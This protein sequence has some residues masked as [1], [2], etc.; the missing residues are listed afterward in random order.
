MTT[1]LV[2]KTDH[3][4]DGL[5]FTITVY[6]CLQL[7]FTFIV[8]QCTYRR[9]AE[10]HVKILSTPRQVIVIQVFISGRTAGEILLHFSDQF[11]QDLIHLIS[12]K[13]TR[14]LKKKI[15]M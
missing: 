15:T 14:D 12:G 7:Q 5:Q 2:P 3:K 8:L 13:Q 4:I 9:E 10:S 1:V 6:S 11:L